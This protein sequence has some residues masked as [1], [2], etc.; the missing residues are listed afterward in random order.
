M[1]NNMEMKWTFY[2][3]L[4]FGDAHEKEIPYKM[5]DGVT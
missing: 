4:G 3:F 5:E 2:L 1:E